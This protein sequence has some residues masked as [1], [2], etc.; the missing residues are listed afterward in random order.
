LYFHNFILEEKREDNPGPFIGDIQFQAFL[1]FT[2][3][4]V[5]WGKAHKIFLKREVGLDLC[6]RGE[7][8]KSF[9][10]MRHKT[11]M[12]R[13]GVID[14]LS[15]I[16]L[17]VIRLG[18]NCFR[19]LKEEALPASKLRWDASSSDVKSREPF[20]Y[21]NFFAATY[22]IERYSRFLQE[23]GPP[24]IG[25]RYNPPIIWFPPENYQKYYQIN[26]KR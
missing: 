9:L 2:Q 26:K 15:P 8:P 7:P 5:R 20:R 6:V 1:S 12:K 13:G 11:F 24:W 17:P 22:I 10:A 14:S 21:K 16:H 19:E 25:C 18:I 4:Q 3:N 23:E